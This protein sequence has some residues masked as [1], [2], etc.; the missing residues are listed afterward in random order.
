MRET[1]GKDFN[2]SLDLLL[3]EASV[4]GSRVLLGREPAVLEELGIR[5]QA[6]GEHVWNLS[7]PKGTND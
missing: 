5:P 4:L 2:P 7:P 1:L 3:K 6:G